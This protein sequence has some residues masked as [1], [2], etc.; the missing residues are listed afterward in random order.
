[1][2]WLLH[3]DGRLLEAVDPRLGD[4]YIAEEAE[5]LLLL[6]LACSHP[7]AN[8]RP[9][10]LAILQIISG[11]APVPTVPPFKPAFIWPAGGPGDMDSVDTM[12]MTSSTFVSGWSPL[13]SHTE[14]V[15]IETSTLLV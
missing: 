4:D 12:S 1:M 7:N 14:V 15:M 9:N 8:E 13:E 3:R 5:R 10:A 2:V 6:G 11:T